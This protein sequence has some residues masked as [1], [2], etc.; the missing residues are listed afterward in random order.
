MDANWIYLDNNATTAPAPEV[1][2]AINDCL[3]NSW[4]NASS[5]HAV[6]QISKQ[7]LV[8]ARATI[9]K[10]LGCKP[11]EVIFTSGA[12][13]SNHM[14]ILGAL[15][16]GESRRL[17]MSAG[18]HASMQKLA[19]TLAGQGVTVDFIPVTADG[20]LDLDA[21]KA[22]I[23]PDAALVSVMSA[24]NE[25]GVLM[26][27][28]EIAALCKAAGVPLHVDATQSVGKLP[29]GFAESGADLVSV[30]AHKLRGPKGVGVLL[31]KS[32]L[33]WPALFAGSQERN[34]RGGTENLPGIAGFA[35][36]CERLAT[37]TETIPETAARVA[38][39]RDCLE[40]GLKAAIPG[41]V[42][43]AA[44]APRLPNTL[45]LR[46]GAIDADVVLNRIEKLGVIASSGSACSAGGSE[47]SAL[48]V[49]MGVPRDL[50]LCAVRLSLSDAT[51]DA[52]IARV[53]E[54][55]PAALGPLLGE[56][57]DPGGKQLA[58]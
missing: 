29:F 7:K 33:A 42:V 57:S 35:A 12:T 43:F 25:T 24:N 55:I 58:A 40:A 34:R 3:L 46:F 11:A 51:T 15:Q 26:P 31:M 17:V 32:G 4:G 5:S 49:A 52:E 20:T 23:R 13:E 21:A 10:F 18:E 39:M 44:G 22:L 53:I 54:A 2:A 36:A 16:R 50:A 1:V 45:Y 14:A 19:R 41:T 27:V 48:L 6:G 8:A 47:P 37:G 28:A 9:A 56:Q 30:S 38:A